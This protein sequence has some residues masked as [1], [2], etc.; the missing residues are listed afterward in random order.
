M[1]HQF[2][3]EYTWGGHIAFM[4]YQRYLAVGA[5]HSFEDVPAGT[6]EISFESRRTPGNQFKLPP[7]ARPLPP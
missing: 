3:N 5:H 6:Y 2:R 7:K 1:K 4:G